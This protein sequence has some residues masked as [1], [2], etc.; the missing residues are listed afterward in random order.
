MSTIKC[1][2]CSHSIDVN[3]VFAQQMEQDYKE[4]LATEKAK[5]DQ[6]NKAREDQLKSKEAEFEEKKA[7][8]NELFK[9]RMDKEREQLRS[10]LKS[11]VEEEFQKQMDSQKQELEEKAKVIS[12]LRNKEVEMERLKRQ[13]LEDKQN[14]ELE[15]EKKLGEKMEAEKKALEDKL[16]NKLQS[17]FAQQMKAQQE[18]L[19]EKSKM[20]SELRDKEIE[21]ERMKREMK[22]EKKNWEYEFEKK[23]QKEREEYEEQ[24]IKREHQRIELKMKERDK[25]IADLK[26]QIDEAKRKAEQGS[27]QLQGEVQEL[28][29]EEYLSANFPFD[30]VVEVKKGARGGDCIQIVNDGN[31]VNCGSIYYESKRTKDFQPAWI[32]KFKADMRVKGADIGVIVTEAMPKDMKMMGEKSGIWICTFEEF[33]ALSFVLRNTVI[34]V[35]QERGSQ[36]NKGDKMNLLY[37]YLTSSEFRMQVEGIVE[38]FTQMQTDL[39]RE[40]NSMNRIWSQREKQIQKVILNTTNMFGSIKGIAGAA[41]GTIDYLELPDGEEDTE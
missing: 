19:E 14:W 6:I 1:P 15:Y 32:E 40:K 29:I 36:Q 2:N 31:Q 9:E 23:I 3:E 17:D 39:Q 35:S 26:T 21:M 41:I 28:A 33:K 11:K 12:D 13:M 27:M 16:K 22:E 24:I 37:D 20:I 4:K 30:E 5:I 18:E 34:L 25:V 8:M 10:Q 38:G 7:K